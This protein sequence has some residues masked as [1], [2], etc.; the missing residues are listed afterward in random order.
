MKSIIVSICVM[1]TAA[2][3]PS[4]LAEDLATANNSLIS[5]GGMT[6]QE[7]AAILESQGHKAEI[8]SATDIDVEALGFAFEV[9]S[10]N[11]NNSNRCTEFLFIVG[12]DLPD[13]FPIEKINE[14]NAT[15]LGGRAFLDADRDPFLDHPVSVSSPADK[16]AFIEA[17]SLWLGALQDFD[18]FLDDHLALS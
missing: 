2:L 18:K 16:N 4:A 7:V 15:Q 9:V 10:Y 5:A 1:W 14:W 12:Y 6:L 13:G 17:T 11:C 3:G 8:T